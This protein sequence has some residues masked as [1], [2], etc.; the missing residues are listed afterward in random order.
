MASGAVVT[1]LAVAWLTWP[2]W[3]SPAL[4]G[5]AGE[6]MVNLLVPANPVFAVNGVLRERLGYWAE[7]SLAY[8]FTSLS[9]DVSYGVPESVL[10]CVLL[11]G[12]IGAGCVAL[13]LLIDWRKRPETSGP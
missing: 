6:Q 11:H 1:V 13:V 10:A 2:I 8:R 7:Q 12:G 5:R 9:D 4:H 3:L